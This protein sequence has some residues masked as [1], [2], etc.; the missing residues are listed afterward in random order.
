MSKK[1]VGIDI[2]SY[3]FDASNNQITLIDCPNLSLENL[4]IITNVTD[5][6]QIYNFADEALNAT[7]SNNVITL[8]YN[9][10]SMSNSDN[11]QIFIEDG[12]T[13][14]DANAIT[15]YIQCLGV[16][17]KRLL[18]AI[19]YPAWLDRA[20]NRLRMTTLVESG[21]ITTVTTCSTVSTVSNI[22]NIG[23]YSATN[24]IEKTLL[25]NWN[26]GIRTRINNA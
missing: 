4:L 25:N 8:E 2:G 12:Q 3:T 22:T 11:L 14:N 16:C 18:D 17:M 5:G 23:G 13:S 21:T 7:I 10:V 24:F 20:L 6:I 26:N 19:K 15:E 9:T 1:I